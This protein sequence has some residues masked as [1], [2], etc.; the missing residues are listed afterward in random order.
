MKYL[1][2]IRARD[3]AWT[4]VLA[5]TGIW[6]PLFIVTSPP[7][8]IQVSVNPAILVIC[9]VVATFG[10]AVKIFGYL[11]TRMPGKVGVVSVSIELAGL[12]L[13]TLAPVSYV[14]A[15]IAGFLDPSTPI[16]FSSAFILACAILAMYAYRA[17]IV[18]PRF[19]LEA[20]D[21]NKE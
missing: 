5:I 12:I 8:F 19:R 18:I 14:V 3:W 11:G 6:W 2:L 4:S 13:A 1:K 10:A 15:S 20:H 7:D 16:N 17:I 21:P 9:M